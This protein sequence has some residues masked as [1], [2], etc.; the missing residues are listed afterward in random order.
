M[1]GWQW[2]VRIICI[3][4]IILTIL[5]F[6]TL[7]KKV[8]S[9]PGKDSIST[10]DKKKKTTILEMGKGIIANK[11]LMLIC[12]L[13][14]IRGFTHR[15]V[16]VFIPIFLA[17]QLAWSIDQISYLYS[18]MVACGIAGQFCIGFVGDRIGLTRVLMGLLVGTGLCVVGVATVTV[19]P[20]LVFFILTIGFFN[21][22]IR[23]IMWSFAI[24]SSTKE[25]MP[26]SM[27]ALDFSNQSLATLSPVL[28]GVVVDFFGI[29]PA[30]AMYAATY[31]LAGLIAVYMNY[32]A[33]KNSAKKG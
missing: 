14:A 20:M 12:L 23:P 30:L 32:D 6:F 15:G 2:A 18:F 24:A 10:D 25:A 16:T 8:D 9:A 3:V 5:V 17:T 33:K 29:R 11:N 26:M 4:S 19:V 21:Y 1:Y 27:S 22:G 13:G 7:P 28:G 31:F